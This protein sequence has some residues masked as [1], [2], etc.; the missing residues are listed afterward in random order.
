[1]KLEWINVYGEKGVCNVDLDSLKNLCSVIDTSEYCKIWRIA[2]GDA[3]VENWKKYKQ[4]WSS[5]DFQRSFFD[6]EDSE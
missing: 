3:N 6:E 5:T 4:S 2:N 1:M